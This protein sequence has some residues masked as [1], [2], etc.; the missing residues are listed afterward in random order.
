MSKGPKKNRT[1]R[2]ANSLQTGNAPIGSTPRRLRSAEEREAHA[3][4][5]ERYP[6]MR[7]RVSGLRRI[8]ERWST[9]EPGSV[10]GAPANSILTRS[11]QEIQ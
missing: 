11:Q 9:R 2:Q 4:E 5:L 3:R 10:A 1:A 6:S 8:P 7:F